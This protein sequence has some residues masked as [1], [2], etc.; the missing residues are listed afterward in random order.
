MSRAQRPYSGPPSA[1]R[2]GAHSGRH[3]KNQASAPP[4]RAP[5]GRST[6]PRAPPA[7][8]STIAA[9]ASPHSSL[10]TRATR[11]RVLSV[12]PSARV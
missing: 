7:L 9:R 11:T 2:R 6:P 3:G 10:V 1:G 5:I 8:I 12:Q 4:P